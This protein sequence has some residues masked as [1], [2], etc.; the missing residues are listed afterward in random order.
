MPPLIYAKILV[1][2]F[3]NINIQ[4]EPVNELTEGGVMK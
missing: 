4:L 2:G 3:E 1:Q